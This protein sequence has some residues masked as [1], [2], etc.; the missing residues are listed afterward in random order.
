VIVVLLAS[1]CVRHIY[2]YEPKVRDYRGADYA[3]Q[4]ANRTEGSLWSEG[5]HGLFEDARARR[6]GDILTIRIDERSDANRDASTKT[7]RTSSALAGVS[8][9]FGAI[10]QLAATNPNVDPQQLISAI[11]EFDFEGE[12]TTTRSGRLS[13]VLPVHIRRVLANGD[14]YVEGHKVL[15]LNEE[16]SHLY[17][18]GVVRPIDIQPDNS[19]PSS[20]LADVEV[21]YTGRGVVTERQT[22]GWGSRILDTIWPF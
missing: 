20:V 7:N 11:T 3:D 9:L 16:E 8:A 12:G 1:G 22:P 15:L 5:A 10:Q 19:I 18:S 13:A 6:V 4:N 21:E 2:P 17:L 14:F